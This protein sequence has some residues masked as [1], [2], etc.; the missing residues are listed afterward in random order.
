MA[1]MTR[2]L[3]SIKK[4]F[5]E[6]K[7]E[8]RASGRDGR[9]FEACYASGNSSDRQC[10]LGGGGA[11]GGGEKLSGAPAEPKDDTDAV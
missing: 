7:I 8:V 3:L 1:A 4:G 6:H 11:G 2:P 5:Y 9:H 10:R